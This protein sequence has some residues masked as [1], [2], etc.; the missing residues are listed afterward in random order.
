VTG[1][2]V[3]LAVDPSLTVLP[4][5]ASTSTCSRPASGSSTSPARAST[6]QPWP[7]PS[8]RCGGLI[9]CRATAP[10]AAAGQGIARCSTGLSFRALRV[11]CEQAFASTL[12]ESGCPAV[13]FRLVAWANVH[14]RGGFM[15][16]PSWLEHGVEKHQ[17]DVLR[18]SIAMNADPA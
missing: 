2:A 18:I 5:A 10:R 11:A 13:R 9:P 17:S 14:D 7:K 3:K 16:F 4:C 8:L 12:A 15:L 6:R 1:A